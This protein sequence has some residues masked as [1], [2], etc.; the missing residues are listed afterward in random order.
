[1][2]TT[3]FIALFSQPI[4]VRII[5]TFSKTWLSASN[6]QFKL[7]AIAEQWI[8]ALV[9]MQKAESFSIFRPPF[10][11]P[12]HCNV[13]AFFLFTLRYSQSKQTLSS[14]TVVLCDET[15]WNEQ[16]LMIWFIFI[17]TLIPLYVRFYLFSKS[18]YC[19]F[20]FN[21]LYSMQSGTHFHTPKFSGN[22]ERNSK[23]FILEKKTHTKLCIVLMRK[24][25]VD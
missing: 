7:M 22:E 10:F 6:Y 12:F 2:A 13:I 20:H 25:S 5:F 4:V 24:T 9:R 23:Y 15:A 21:L 16:W 17:I 11:I 19:V 18:F 8:K 3:I 1:M 14:R